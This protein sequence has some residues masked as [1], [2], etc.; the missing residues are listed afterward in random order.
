MPDYFDSDKD[1]PLIVLEVL[2]STRDFGGSWIGTNAGSDT[3]P[4][5]ECDNVDSHPSGQI[6]PT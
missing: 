3:V 2:Y 5:N 1:Q 4:N 6:F